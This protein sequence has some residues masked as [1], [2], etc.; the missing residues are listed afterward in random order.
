[1]SW[2]GSA[3]LTIN[4]EHSSF[5]T[6]FYRNTTAI[7]DAIDHNDMKGLGKI[8]GGNMHSYLEENSTER[9]DSR[10]G[11]NTHEKDVNYGPLCLVLDELGGFVDIEYD[12]EASSSSLSKGD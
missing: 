5:L 9:Q 1:M 2:R 10:N 4:L 6:Y 8:L 12:S 7:A 3:T 11:D